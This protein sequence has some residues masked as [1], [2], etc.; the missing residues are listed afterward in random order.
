MRRKKIKGHTVKFRKATKVSVGQLIDKITGKQ[1][2][3]FYTYI[4]TLTTKIWMLRLSS[5]EVAM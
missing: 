2:K 1:A 3:L 5:N 4:I